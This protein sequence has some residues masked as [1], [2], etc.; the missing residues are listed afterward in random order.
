MEI[1]NQSDDISALMA[2]FC[3]A[4]AE[5]EPVKKTGMSNRG[6]YAT[7]DDFGAATS[8]ALQKNDISIFYHRLPFTESS[9]LL[10]ARIQ[11]KSGQF[12]DSVTLAP[13]KVNPTRTEMDEIQGNCT[14]LIRYLTKEL[15]G[16][17]VEN[18]SEPAEKNYTS[19]A[20]LT[21]KITKNQLNY[22]KT[23]V[24]SSTDVL[25]GILRV[26]KVQSLE[27][28]TSQEASDFISQ[29]KK[30]QPK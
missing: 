24:G 5:F 29:M 12:F 14:R 13:Y 4:Q 9:M 28:L 23:L 25:N 11:H 26:A 15:L 6:P 8:K 7:L 20:P 17:M 16:L 1:K 18:D 19:S 27:E 3:K 22:L 30:V 10:K 2:A 21:G